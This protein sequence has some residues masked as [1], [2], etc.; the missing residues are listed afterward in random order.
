MQKKMFAYSLLKKRGFFTETSTNSYNKSE[1][2]DFFPLKEVL[3]T[4]F[5]EQRRKF[6]FQTNLVK[7]IMQDK[8]EMGQTCANVSK[9][10]A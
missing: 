10:D 8:I 5:T 7:N 6:V 4:Y 3:R 1:K 2:N 9:T